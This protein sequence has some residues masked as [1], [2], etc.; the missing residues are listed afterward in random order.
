[1]APYRQNRSPKQ[2]WEEKRNGFITSESIDVGFTVEGGKLEFI[3]DW[4][5]QNGANSVVYFSLSTLSPLIQ[6]I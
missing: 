3:L 4:S 1:M 2:S 6:R 5:Y